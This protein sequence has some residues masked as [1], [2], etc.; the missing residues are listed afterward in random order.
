MSSVYNS[1]LRTQ[2]ATLA[3]A[4]RAPIAPGCDLPPIAPPSANVQ[5]N[6]LLSVPLSNLGAGDNFVIPSLS[7]RKLIY[8]V[9]LWNVAAQTITFYQGGGGGGI[10]LCPLPNFPAL[11]GLSLGFNGNFAQAHF[12]IDSG[13]QFNINLSVGSAVG[14]F[15]RYRIATNDF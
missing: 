8:E 4:Y 5:R 6:Q 10:L 7:G 13:Q 11:T 15:I 12:D 9:F 2:A 1:L 14:G 3:L